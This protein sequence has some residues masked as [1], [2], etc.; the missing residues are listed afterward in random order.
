MPGS[1]NSLPA[2]VTGSSASSGSVA[3][4]DT[5]ESFCF[6]LILRSLRPEIASDP[7]AAKMR[8]PKESGWY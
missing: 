3:T 6:T 7:I 8:Y 4:V 2:G 1:M 5:A